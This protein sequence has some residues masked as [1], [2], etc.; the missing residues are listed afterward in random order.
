MADNIVTPIA[1]G[2]I[3]ATDD[4]GGILYP[5]TKI[6]LGVDG[7]AV[8]LSSTNPMPITSSGL[9]TGTDK[10]GN[11]TTGGTAQTLAAVNTTRKALYGQNISTT[12]LWINEL[13]NPAVI[14][15][16]GSWKIASGESFSISTNRAVSVIG[17]TTGQGFTAL[18]V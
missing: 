5:R 12:D 9:P 2:T 7:S 16:A 8:D 4:I 17:A 13:G 18:E 11:I 15:T 14:G 3:F 6:S 10:S 1:T